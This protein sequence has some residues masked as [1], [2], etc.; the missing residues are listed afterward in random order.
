MRLIW[1]PAARRDLESI[2]AYIAERNADAA[3]RLK[4]VIEGV[5]ERLPEHPFL[6]RPG[7]VEGMREAVVHPNYIVMYRVTADAVEITTVIHARREYP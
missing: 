7:R 4:S 6:Y 1:L 5:T 3:Q 2:I